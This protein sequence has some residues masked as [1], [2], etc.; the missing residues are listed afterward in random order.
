MPARPKLELAFTCGISVLAGGLS[1]RL[2]RD[3]TRVR[4]GP[5]TLL[6][7]VRAVAGELGLPV[8]IIRR[9]LVPRCGPVGGVFT[10]LK[11]SPNQAELFLACDMPFLSVAFLKEF[12][13]AI[14]ARDPA[15][16]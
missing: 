6:G 14:K 13:G 5:L 16:F 7:V 4:L 3:K 9:D 8:R 11:T 2:G 1:Q 10:G 15:A 12:L